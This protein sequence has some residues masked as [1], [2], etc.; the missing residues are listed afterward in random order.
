MSDDNNIFTPSAFSRSDDDRG[1]VGD[2]SDSG[3]LSEPV[4]S[5]NQCSWGEDD[6]GGEGGGDERSTLA[7][8]GD[9]AEEGHD[10]PVAG[11]DDEAS[12]R[13]KGS[14]DILVEAL[15]HGMTQKEAGR[16]AGMA[17][18]TVSRRRKE[19]PD[20][21]ERVSE[22]RAELD[23]ERRHKLRRLGGRA[24]DGTELAMSCAID[25]LNSEDPQVQL[26]A[27]RLLLQAGPKVHQGLD[28]EDHVVEL[29]ARAAEAQANPPAAPGA[30]WPE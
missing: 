14:D 18:R 4:I 7:C 6:S 25:L 30:R 11:H 10:A 13:R 9:T 12:P 22:R 29:E 3:T 1:E 17:E 5:A 2:A 23:A 19:E 24:L 27:A 15:A 21:A 8:E 16:Q 26:G 20:L 28:L